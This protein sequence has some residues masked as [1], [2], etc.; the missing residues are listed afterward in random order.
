MSLLAFMR[1]SLSQ[2]GGYELSTLSL[3]HVPH[4]RCVPSPPS[5]EDRLQAFRAAQRPEIGN[6]H[7]WA[8]RAREYAAGERGL[9]ADECQLGFDFKYGG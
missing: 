9:S 5:N 6:S 7:P 1:G 2:R 8:F 3:A 4:G